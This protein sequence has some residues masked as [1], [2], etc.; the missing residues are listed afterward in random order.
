M[1]IH[2]EN[3]LVFCFHSPVH[4]KTKTG[5]QHEAFLKD[6]IPFNSTSYRQGKNLKITAKIFQ[7]STGKM[8]LSHLYM[9]HSKSAIVDG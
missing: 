1:V 8:C 4:I 5:Q 7:L 3:S 9:L 6:R 2:D